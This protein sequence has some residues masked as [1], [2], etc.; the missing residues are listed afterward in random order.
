M[1][2][3]EGFG[4]L[5]KTPGKPWQRQQNTWCSA[6]CMPTFDFMEFGGRTVYDGNGYADMHAC[7]GSLSRS[8]PKRARP[9]NRF[10]K[11]FATLASLTVPATP[12]DT[13]GSYCSIL[14]N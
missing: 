13:T 9:P 7:P 12:S 8:N 5:P 11:L 4:T 14:E 1:A 10:L 3:R 2:R 6:D